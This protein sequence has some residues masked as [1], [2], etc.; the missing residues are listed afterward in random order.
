MGCG[1]MAGGIVRDESSQC[2]HRL[3]SHVAGEFEQ[4][5]PLIWRE[6]CSP[7]NKTAALRSTVAARR[8]EREE[9][10]SRRV[11]LARRLVE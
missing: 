5:V 7:F 8:A 6:F 11:G 2:S 10:Q 9:E 1:G 3:R 4:A